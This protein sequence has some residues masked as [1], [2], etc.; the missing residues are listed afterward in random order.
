MLHVLQP[1]VDS[2]ESLM[3]LLADEETRDL[4]LDDEALFRAV[5]ERRDCLRISTHFYFYIL[6]RQVFR[7]SGIE[8]REVADY[9][10]ELL[11]EFS[12]AESLRCRLPG[13]NHP[14]DYFVDMLAALQTADDTTTFYLRAHIGNRSLFLAGIFPDH[15]HYRLERHGAPDLHYYESLGRENYHLASDHRLARKY[16]VAGIFNILAERFQATR[17]ALN[18]LGERLV[19]LSGFDSSVSALLNSSFETGN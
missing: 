3:K 11:A 12:S 16:D 7:R 4:V 18:D 1:G 9:V 14:L 5:L 15:I 10:A 13:Q 2:P 17:L 6:V 8:E 19:A